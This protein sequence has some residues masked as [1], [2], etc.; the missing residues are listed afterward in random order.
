MEVFYSS[1][2]FR[3]CLNGFQKVFHPRGHLEHWLYLCRNVQRPSLVSWH[4]GT[5]S[6]ATHLSTF[7]HTQR[8]N[9]PR[10]QRFT[11]LPKIGTIHHHSLPLSRIV[12][13]FGARNGR[14]NV[15][16]VFQ[17]VGVSEGSGGG[18]GGGG[19]GVATTTVW[20]L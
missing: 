5:A 2:N 3:E 14:T 8:R 6:I 19:G 20:S 1:Q 10:H 12:A 16:F 11:G 7:G 18:G 17:N 9:L 4:V 15:G 13:K